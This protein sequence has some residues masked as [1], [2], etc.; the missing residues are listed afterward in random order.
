M[1]SHLCFCK[2]DDEDDEVEDE[3]TY[4][5]AKASSPLAIFKMSSLITLGMYIDEFC[6][7]SAYDDIGQQYVTRSIDSTKN[8][9]NFVSL[10][11][12]GHFSS[13]TRYLEKSKCVF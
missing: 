2:G 7:V 5:I 13:A 10:S 12:V 9:A 11:F 1:T 4:L 8:D 6:D 3:F